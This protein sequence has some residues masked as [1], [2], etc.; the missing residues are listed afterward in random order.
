MV[1]KHNL[2]QFRFNREVWLDIVDLDENIENRWIDVNIY[3]NH[4]NFFSI[5]RHSGS[6]VFYSLS[7]SALA[8]TSLM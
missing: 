6:D 5:K 3:K 8:L 1:N 2:L 7:D 4:I